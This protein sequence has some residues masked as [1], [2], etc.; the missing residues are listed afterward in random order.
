M[1]EEDLYDIVKES[2]EREGYYPVKKSPLIRIRGY[3]PDVT[4]LKGKEVVCFEIKPNF[5]EYSAMAAMTQA[6]V[7]QF[8]STHT[9][10]AFPEG[11]W[12]AADEKLRE[13]VI[14]LCKDF[15]LGIQLIETSSKRIRP[16][17]TPAFNANISL[18]DYDYVIE[19][20][21]GVEWPILANSYPEY[22]R[23]VCKY[24][25]Q[26]NIQEITRKELK[27][28]LKS[29]FSSNYWLKESRS[30]ATI[31]EAVS[32]RVEAS[33]KAAIDLGL[34][35]LRETMDNSDEDKL[36]LSYSGQL[37]NEISK[38]PLDN[39]NPQEL[40]DPVSAFL[41]GLMM[42]LPVI[43]MAIEILSKREKPMLLGQ[44]K[45]LSCGKTYWDIR[46]LE[47]KGDQLLCRKCKKEV[48]VCLIH[49]LQIE[50][51]KAEYWWPIHFT[52]SLNTTK[53]LYIFRFSYDS[54]RLYIALRH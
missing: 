51:G 47:R 30:S 15:N 46:E 5:D 33:L 22:V 53:S 23:D 48:D 29:D 21:E 39:K 31:Q 12:Q 49:K 44:S 9:F 4:G 38:E 41:S 17:V 2:L 32:N 16:I 13:L 18:Q 7:Y 8:G 26:N 10:V 40:S 34:L 11:D 35:E 27:D 1:K 19:Q 50:H 36:S 42:K 54:R 28:K 6:R 14:K 24:V 43:Q 52:K 25:A 45:C 20:L 37:L 3:K